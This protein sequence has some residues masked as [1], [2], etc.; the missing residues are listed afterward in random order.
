[1]ERKGV[2]EDIVMCEESEIKLKW[3]R[4]QKPRAG[5]ANTQYDVTSPC[6]PRPLP[7]SIPHAHREP[8]TS[9]M[10]S[11]HGASQSSPT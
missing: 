3:G 7:K 11:L 1:M 8:Q 9:S 4:I 6:L 10:M 5:R 2:C